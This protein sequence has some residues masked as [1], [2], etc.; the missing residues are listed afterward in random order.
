MAGCAIMKIFLVGGAVRDQLLNYPVKER[1][2]VV[3]GSTPQHML[4]QGYKQV[5]RDFPVFL[6]PKT[7]E[8]YALARRERKNGR[9]YYGFI[10]DS[11]AEVTLEEDLQRRDLTINALARDEAGHL[12]DPYQGLKDIQNKVLRHISPSFV[13]DPVRVL[14]VARFAARYHHLGFK[15]APETRR[16]MYSMVKQGELAYLV[17]ERV[18]QEVEKSLSEKNPELFF[19]TLR[20]CGALR[21]I[22]PEI[23]ALFG[24]P[25]PSHY[26]LEI[27]SGVHTLMVLKEAAAL[28]LDP[29]IRF[30][31][32]VHDLGKALT[33][34]RLWPK[35]HN[36]EESGIIPIQ[37]LCDRLRIP[38]VYRRL[39]LLGCKFHLIIH[40]LEELK[41][42]TIVKAL[43]AVD[44][45][46]RP[47]QL[48]D[49]LII[50]KADAG[51]CGRPLLNYQQ[52]EK[53]QY[54][55]NENAK[56]T[57]AP[58]VAEQYQGFV[59]KEKLHEQRVLHTQT[60][61]NNWKLNEK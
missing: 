46:R 43:E 47:Q 53:W 27:D 36:H 57:A 32:L 20:S 6:H 49:L 59:I 58:F 33:P 50:C 45:F 18:W 28:S 1:D 22:F 7:N 4:E 11:S 25:N 40:R 38:S 3:V 30:A 24:V 61:L 31:A 16:L 19:T 5:G 21:I 55:L 51:G 48:K 10:C 60:I 9:G 35:H 39:A 14:R 17:V 34:M 44:A 56:I 54:L 13:E 42:S 15:L 23:D 37:A 2:W 41:A 29:K 26:H 52:D 12:I 8:E